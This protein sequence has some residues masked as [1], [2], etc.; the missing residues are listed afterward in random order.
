MISSQLPLALRLEPDAERQVIQIFGHAV[1]HNIGRHLPK[2][3][4]DIAAHAHFVHAVVNALVEVK[5]VAAFVQ[6]GGE[7]VFHTIGV[8]IDQSGV[9]QAL[10]GDKVSL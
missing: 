6:I 9:S 10:E 7:I 3:Q 8:H 5:P 1:G 2:Y 4:G